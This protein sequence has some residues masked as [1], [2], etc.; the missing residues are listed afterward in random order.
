[1]RKPLLRITAL[2]SAAAMLVPALSFAQQP[3]PAQAAPPYSPQTASPPGAYPPGANAAGAYPPGGYPPGAYPSG[4]GVPPGYVPRL[5]APPAWEWDAKRERWRDTRPKTLP[6]REGAAPPEGY[7]YSERVNLA[8]TITGASLFGIAYLGSTLG[9]S[10]A[11]DTGHPEWAPLFI[12]IAGPFIALATADD[13][14]GR[15]KLRT[16][17]RVGLVMDGL[18]Q[19]GGATML[20]AALVSRRPT[21]RRLDLE[22]PPPPSFVPQVSVG[23]RGMSA[24]MLF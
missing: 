8:L 3:A 7:E 15:S 17:T 5:T 14:I 4:Y 20:I 13:E 12:P 21:F 6:A 22:P 9:A 2:L 1:M 24:R 16:L 10:V 19:T 11:L 23:P 18:I